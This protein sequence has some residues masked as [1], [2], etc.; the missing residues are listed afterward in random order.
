MYT[1][2]LK[3]LIEQIIIVNINLLKDNVIIIGLGL[4]HDEVEQSKFAF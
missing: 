1:S 2:F 3:K 4:M